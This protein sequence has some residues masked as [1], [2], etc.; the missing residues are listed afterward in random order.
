MRSLRTHR[1]NEVNPTYSGTSVRLAGWVVNVRVLGKLVFVALRDATGVMQLITDQPDLV[2]RCRQL[3]TGCAISAAGVVALRQ[4]RDVNLHQSTGMLEVSIED[5]TWWPSDGT[6]EWNIFS[7]DISIPLEAKMRK[8]LV[9]L[10]FT[11]ISKSI[12]R[13]LSNFLPAY[14]RIFRI[15]S[16]FAAETPTVKSTEWSR[17]LESEMAFATADDLLSVVHRLFCKLT[18]QLSVRGPD[19]SIITIPGSSWNVIELETAEHSPDLYCV[20]GLPINGHPKLAGHD[21]PL[22][23]LSENLLSPAN[24]EAD[25]MA[26]CLLVVANGSVVAAGAVHGQGRQEEI[27]TL[28][29]VSPLAWHALTGVQR[30]R[31][32]RA[33]HAWFCVDVKRLADTMHPEAIRGLKVDDPWAS[34]AHGLAM[35]LQ[36]ADTE[37]D[38]MGQDELTGLPTLEA[39]RYERWEID[40]YSA[41]ARSRFTCKSG[42]QLRDAGDFLSSVR[43][44]I[45]D[46]GI[47]AEVCERLFSIVPDTKDR[48][49]RLPPGERFRFVWSILGN[50]PIRTALD[51]DICYGIL[52]KAG[53]LKIITDLKQLIYFDDG[54]IKDLSKV[55]EIYGGASN[56]EGGIVPHLRQCFADS[57]TTF[58]AL[59]AALADAD[60]TTVMTVKRLI[61]A[62]DFSVVVKATKE[63]LCTPAFFAVVLHLIESGD[64]TISLTDAIRSLGPLIFPNNPFLASDIAQALVSKWSGGTK[65]CNAFL[66]VKNSN[67][68]AAAILHYLF[69]PVVQS[70]RQFQS[71]LYTV[72]DN[73][74]H[75][76]L[77]GLRAGGRHWRSELSCFEFPNPKRTTSALRLFLSKNCPSF[78]A[79]GTVGICTAGDYDLFSRPDHHH[80]N[81]VDAASGLVVGNVQFHLLEND[82]SRVLLVRAI[83]AAN[84]YLDCGSAREI[85][86]ASLISCLELAVNSGL[87][88]V[89]LV[90]GLSFWHLNSSRPQ[91]RAVLESFY[92]VLPSVVLD[93]PFFLFH[94]RHVP[95]EVT[96]TFRLW[97]PK[98]QVMRSL[99]LRN[100]FKAFF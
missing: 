71:S 45:D 63:W 28:R 72:K 21:L 86:E 22:T 80:L 5:F 73:T 74:E 41:M 53:R 96:K 67:D 34:V 91:I 68:I 69:R 3:K 61:K 84:S 20:W 49:Q 18:A 26:A 97:A 40:C 55:I 100:L 87:D 93:Q 54:A 70:F 99:R 64:T 75:I 78:L 51:A 38:V 35:L 42:V 56:Q 59:L 83:N 46:F 15:R 39:R 50:D 9:A 95:V 90:E 58:T 60:T 29:F 6:P 43:G 94:Y 32:V 13:S 33:P 16:A 17:L 88:E 82:G 37:R 79:K 7:P 48:F 76:W 2:Q 8:Q 27:D 52:V 98:L 14:D 19:R 23:L 24:S 89:H 4:T 81:I 65:E 36:A 25:K 44:L 1:C 57:P 30:E 77:S 85:V 62:G 12:D 31:E 92:D 10:G 66:F 11:E 47:S